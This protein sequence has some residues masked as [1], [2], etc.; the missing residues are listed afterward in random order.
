[1]NE[2][3]KTKKFYDALAEQSFNEWF[4]NPA[5]LPILKK[6]ISHLPDKALILDL[7]CGTGGESKRLTTLGARV[8][9]IDFSLKS[10][11]Y[12][13]KYVP[14]ATFIQMDILYMGFESSYFDGILEAGVVFHFNE[15]EQKEILLKINDIL[16]NQGHFLSFYPEGDYEGMQ[17]LTI[18]GVTH[19]RYSRNL[20]IQNW[21]EQVKD[22]GFEELE[23]HNLNIGSFK[24]VEFCK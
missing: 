8:I 24:C 3:E 16:K 23:R 22:C 5:L 18:A 6:F 14:D 4:N 17:E 19:K 1:M 2:R 20:P 21:V 12:A 13:K 11:E 9:G 7:G 10:L 15:Q